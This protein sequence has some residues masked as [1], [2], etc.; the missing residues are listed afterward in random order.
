[1]KVLI[2]AAGR[3]TRISR[4]LSGN[5]KCTVDIG[6]GQ[7]LIRYTVELLKSRGIREIGLVLGYKAQVIRDVLKGQDVSFYYNPF[8]DV[9]NSIASA[10]FA[11]DFLTGGDLLIMNGDV[12]LEE[13]LLDRILEEKKSP[14]MFADESRKETADYKFYYENGILK[15]YG[16][17]L[18]GDDITGEYIGIGCFS[19]EFLPEFVRR[20]EEMIDRQEHSV[21]WENVIYSMTEEQPVYVEDVCGHFWAEVDYIEDYERILEHRGV[22]KIVR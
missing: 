12:Y 5:P 10:W 16:K 4:Y 22:E 14:V 8:Y 18:E 21:W 20:M 1:M 11:K 19:G 15:K 2:L 13:R 9:T 6:E 3:G 17:E 7:C